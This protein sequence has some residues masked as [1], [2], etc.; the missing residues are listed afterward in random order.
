VRSGER[1][2]CQDSYCRKLPGTKGFG[3]FVVGRY[4]ESLGYRWIH[5]DYNVFGGNRLGKYPA[6]EE[7]LR[8]YFGDER[9]EQGRQFFSPYIHVQ[10]PDLLIYRP[11]F[12]EVR[13]AE[14]KRMDTN[15]RLNEAQ[16]RGLALLKLLYDCE[17]EIFYVAEEGKDVPDRSFVWE[18]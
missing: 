15:D 14:V 6:A 4:F 3:E 12:S 7:V 13:F 16:I 2:D 9:Y 1:A 11:D 8:K 18:F 5:H 10:E 17:A